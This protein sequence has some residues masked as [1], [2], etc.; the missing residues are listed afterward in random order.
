MK[1]HGKKNWYIADAYL[2][3]SGMGEK[4][5]GHES[6]CIL[7]AGEREAKI[8][9]YLYFEHCEMMEIEGLILPACSNRHFGMHKPEEIKGVVV[10]QDIPY[11]IR[12]ESDELIIVQYTRLDVTQS[13]FS[14]MTTV[15]YSE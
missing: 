8:S 7:N 11:G 9:F 10:P 12:I 13:N 1:K 5:E 15:P 3:S 2:P 14:L 4:W 6:V